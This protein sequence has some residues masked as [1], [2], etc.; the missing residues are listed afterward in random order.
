MCVCRGQ[1]F[2]RAVGL[3]VPREQLSSLFAFRGHVFLPA[4]AFSRHRSHWQ[5]RPINTLVRFPIP[6]EICQLFGSFC[7]V[8][9]ISL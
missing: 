9:S 3:L 5:F 6:L 1:H 4:V 8:S 2:E 7:F